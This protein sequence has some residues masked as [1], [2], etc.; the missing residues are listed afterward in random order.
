LNAHKPVESKALYRFE[1]QSDPLE[2][3]L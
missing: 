1:S 2:D 3:E